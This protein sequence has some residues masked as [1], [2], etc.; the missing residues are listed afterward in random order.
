MT[1]EEKQKWKEH[2]RWEHDPP[3]RKARRTQAAKARRKRK[4]ANSRHAFTG[5]S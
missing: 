4:L 5:E 3:N 2:Q 1:E